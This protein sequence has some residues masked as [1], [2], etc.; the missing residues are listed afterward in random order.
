MKHTYKV[1]ISEKSYLK[2]K[3]RAMRLSGT[4]IDEIFYNKKDLLFRTRSGTDPRLTW[5]QT[6]RITDLEKLDEISRTKDLDRVI[7]ES[8]I[9]VHCVA[10]DMEV[11]MG[12]NKLRK[13]EGLKSGDVIYSSDMSKQLIIS[14]LTSLHK[15][16]VEL[17]LSNGKTLVCT[18]EHKV[19][20]F[21]GEKVVWKKA[22][23][24]TTDC[25]LVSP[26]KGIHYH[27]SICEIDSYHKVNIISIRYQTG[28]KRFYDIVLAHK[29]HDFICQDVVVSNCTCP[30]F[31]YWGFKYMAWKNGYGLERETRVPRVRNPHQQGYV[32]KHI[33]QCCMV[34]PFISKTVAMKMRKYFKPID[35]KKEEERLKQEQRNIQ[36]NIQMKQGAQGS[37]NDETNNQS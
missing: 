18:L 16:W 11:L 6:I 17:E 28:S 20:I 33:Y 36:N 24:L 14:V 32:C 5:F 37:N 19:R 3:L 2:V 35:D 30:A 15:K 21:N 23:K 12:T 22:S 8:G 10:G 13:V 26:K 1:L 29:P 7:R 34:Y 27:G 25:I 4:F 9:K 31:L